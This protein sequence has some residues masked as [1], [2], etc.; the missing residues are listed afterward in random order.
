MKTLH[1]AKGLSHDLVVT[2]DGSAITLW[3][4]EG[5]R[6]TVF[7]LDFPPVPGL[8][9]AGNT[10]LALA[11]NPDP[12][13][14]LILGLGGGS[15]LRMFRA[16]RP[17]ASIDAVEIDPA[18]PEIARRF[19]QVGDSPGFQIYVEDAA[20]YVER[21][22]KEYDLIILD[23][24]AGDSLPVQCSNLEF[25]ARMRRRLS[26]CGVAVINWM[27]GDHKRYVELLQHVQS[28]VGQAWSLRGQRSRN[29]LLFAS[30][31]PA[32]RQALVTVAESLALEIPF[33]NALPR[34]AH[35]L[36]AT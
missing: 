16:A 1:R 14:I 2:R 36:R 5:V 3:S 19:F 29:T 32:S 25:F 35:R 7:D 6:H 12:G 27:P 20:T 15:M 10:L 30:I 33:P 31:V 21:C 4:G 9:Y 24:Y 17:R 18:I 8:E 11:F 13:S 26:A 22:E 34:L 28:T 23:A